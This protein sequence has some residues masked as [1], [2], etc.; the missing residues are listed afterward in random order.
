MD[1]VIAFMFQAQQKLFFWINRAVAASTPAE[2]P[3]IPNYDELLQH[4]TMSTFK[5]VYP[6]TWQRH[7]ATAKPQ[8]AVTGATGATKSTSK[9]ANNN[10]PDAVLQ[11][12]YRDS[13]SPALTAMMGGA[14]S[15]LIKRVPKAGN[16]AV[17]LAWTLQG[18][19]RTGCER[20]ADHR[21]LSVAVSAAL[22]KFL[23]ECP[24]I[25]APGP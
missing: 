22:H 8:A 11:K 25:K 10:P 16:D 4:F 6:P 2:R 5:G 12:R 19:C 18:K 21:Q 3:R 14:G 20:K 24:G 17:C 15:E 7:F 13:G 1:Q 9:P 23:D